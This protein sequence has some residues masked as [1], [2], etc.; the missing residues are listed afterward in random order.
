MNKARRKG[1]FRA[2]MLKRDPARRA[3]A[4]RSLRGIWADLPAGGTE[5]LLEERRREREREERKI[6]KV[7]S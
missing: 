6:R 2:Q 3:E 5:E 7:G 1:R 4:V